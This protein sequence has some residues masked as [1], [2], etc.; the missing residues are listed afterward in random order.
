MCTVLSEVSRVR[1]DIVSP[2]PMIVLHAVVEYTYDPLVAPYSTL[3]L[4]YL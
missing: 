3:E 4:I 2:P 1:C